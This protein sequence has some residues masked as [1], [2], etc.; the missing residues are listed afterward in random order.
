MTVKET[1]ETTALIAAIVCSLGAASCRAAVPGPERPNIVLILADDVSPEMF[2][3]YGSEE[4]RTPHLDRVAKEGVMF[5]TAWASALCLPSRAAIMTGCYATRTGA[6]SNGF[7]IPQRDGSSELFRHFPSFARLLQDAGYAT[8]VAGKWHV[9]EAEHPSNP[10]VGF[11]EYSLWE[12]ERE[13]TALPGNQKITAAMEN[14]ETPSRYWQPSI[15]QNGK[16]Y[17][18]KPDEFGPDIETDFLCGFMERSVR[19]GKPFLAYLPTAAPHGARNGMPTTPLRGLPGENGSDDRQENARRFRALT[20]YLDVMVGRLERKVRDLGVFDNTVFIFTS[21]NGTAVVAKSRGTERGC[22]VPFIA[23][24]GPVKRWGATDEICDF[25][26][27]LPTLM[28][29]AGTVLP[30]GMEVDGKS[31]KPFLTGESDTHREYI[32]SCIGTT[33]LV[34]SREHLLEVVN[35]IL[36]VPEGRF[37]YCGDSRDGKGYLR[38]DSDPKHADVRERFNGILARHPGLTSDHPCFK[39]ARGAKWLQSYTQPSAAA[40]HLHNHKDY[41]FYDETLPNTQAPPA[42]CTLQ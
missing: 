5:R 8:A 39:T 23:W 36:G 35:P 28:D 11:D 20:D 17:P 1:T 2:G 32:F 24:G 15:V 42:Q 26:D 19:V 25:S 18:S 3:A 29:F 27:I 14:E 10:V 41:Q 13:V 21:D 7:S 12:G 38:V 22:R 6:W 16:V 34:R 9:G 4:A 30:A 40:K 33:R 31:L 37:Y